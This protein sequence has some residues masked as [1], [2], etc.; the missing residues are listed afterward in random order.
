M[1][2]LKII[3]RSAGTALG[4][5]AALSLVCLVIWPDWAEQAFSSR[6]AMAIF[7]MWCIL[8]TAVVH[9]TIQQGLANGWRNFL[10]YC[11]NLGGDNDH[12]W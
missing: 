7:N 12:W 1:R 2:N 3:R 8:M 5:L 10:E 9:P 6:T 11:D 4:I